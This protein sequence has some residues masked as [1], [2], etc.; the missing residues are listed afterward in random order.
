MRNLKTIFVASLIFSSLHASAFALHL[1]D[2]QTT[3]QP[4]TIQASLDRL[5]SAAPNLNPKV[6]TLA[7]ETYN[8]AGAYPRYNSNWTN[9]MAQNRGDTPGAQGKTTKQQ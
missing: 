2:T 5:E 3:S 1:F 6:I 8:K 7:V 4:P 9:N